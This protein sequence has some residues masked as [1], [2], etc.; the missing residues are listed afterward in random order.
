MINEDHEEPVD[1]RRARNSPH[2]SIS[3]TYLDVGN[4]RKLKGAPQNERV[5]EASI[6]AHN[7]RA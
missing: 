7:P 2:P 5:A 3:L 6:R 1:G 4:N